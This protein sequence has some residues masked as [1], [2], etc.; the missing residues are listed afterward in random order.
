MYPC[1][2]YVHVRVGQNRM[3]SPLRHCEPPDMN[4]VELRTHT[5]RVHTLSHRAISPA[6]S[7]TFFIKIKMYRKLRCCSKHVCGISVVNGKDYF[8]FFW[9]IIHR[10]RHN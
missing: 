10:K 2:E 4:A 5:R 1:V 6:P 8:P 9:T 3:L 7:T